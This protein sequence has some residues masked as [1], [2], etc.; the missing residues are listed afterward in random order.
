[1]KFPIKTE[2]LL[3]RP[4]SKDDLQTYVDGINQCG[5][6]QNEFDT[7]A[8]FTEAN[9][10]NFLQSDPSTLSFQIFSPDEQ[11]WLG[12]IDIY[13]MK[14]GP[15]LSANIDYILLN[16]HWGKGYATEALNGVIPFLFL[17]MGLHRIEATI[18]LDNERSLKLIENLN[19]QFEGIKRH[20]VKQKGIW[21]DLKV[22]SRIAE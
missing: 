13:N 7:F 1:M 21:K 3:I 2:R 19:F 20:A 10:H 17:D 16:Q 5:P 22:Y 6:A 18:D 8:G 4:F 15:F 9:F 14:R 11:I 12:T